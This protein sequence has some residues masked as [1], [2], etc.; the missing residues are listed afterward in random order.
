MIAY[1]I[2]GL[3]G[4]LTL[5]KF[6]K[7][8]S[9]LKSSLLGLFLGIL[10]TIIG[11]TGGSFS[12]SSNEYITEMSPATQ[13]IVKEGI[14]KLWVKLGHAPSVTKISKALGIS[15]SEVLHSYQELRGS[16]YV[17][18]MFWPST[19][20]I[21]WLWPFSTLN[22]GITVTLDGGKPVY[23]RCA[24]DSLGI[25]AMFGKPATIVVTSPLWK[26][27]IEIRMNGKKMI[28]V[29]SSTVIVSTGGDCDD[30]L[31]FTSIKEF[32][33]YKKEYKRPNL[34]YYS[35]AIAVDRGVSSF[36]K[37]LSKLKG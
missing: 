10:F 20:R 25:S 23:A 15:E 2:G 27:S 22:H 28:N 33:A 19:N 18:K 3:F 29:T 11:F 7:K 26:K 34:A 14:Y 5:F 32:E 4:V 13:K 24:I 36:G 6:S 30:T 31:F 12:F 16:S 1:V 9:A 35:L 17:R 21:K 8:N 37:V